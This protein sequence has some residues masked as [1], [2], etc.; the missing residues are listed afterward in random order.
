[1]FMIDYDRSLMF[2]SQDNIITFVKKKST[3]FHCFVLEY[4]EHKIPCDY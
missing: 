4:N 3:S 1:M 2:A